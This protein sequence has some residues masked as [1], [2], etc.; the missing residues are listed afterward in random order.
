MII[1]KFHNKLSEFCM[2]FNLSYCALKRALFKHFISFLRLDTT[3]SDRTK[4]ASM[5]KT[6][7]KE[8]KKIVLQNLKS[9][10]KIFV[11]YDVWT[12][13]NKL[14]FFKIIA[15][16]VDK[17]EQYRENFISFWFLKK[18]SVTNELSFEQDSLFGFDSRTSSSVLVLKS[19]QNF[20]F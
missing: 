20:L 17:N 10:I 14:T 6:R 2:N 13:L 18:I 3:L 7:V 19:K 9:F 1:F 11:I 12:N 16:F 15:Y 4:F 5:I 8:I